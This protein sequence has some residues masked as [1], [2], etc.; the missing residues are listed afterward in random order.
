MKKSA[1]LLVTLLFAAVAFASCEPQV[2]PEPEPQPQD[3]I[4]VE[5]QD[6]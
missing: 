1:L 2:T 4:P 5:L 3:T 6:L